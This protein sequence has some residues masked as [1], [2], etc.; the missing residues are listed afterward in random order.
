MHDSSRDLKFDRHTTHPSGL[1]TSP[2]FFG[3][4]LYIGESV[5]IV[6]YVW[7]YDILNI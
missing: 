3:W 5:F 7:K 4:V 1:K 2:Y 6:W